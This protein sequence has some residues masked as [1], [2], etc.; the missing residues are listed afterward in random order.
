MKLCIGKFQFKF[1]CFL[2][3]LAACET[4]QKL[5]PICHW[6]RASEAEIERKIN[7]RLIETYEVKSTIIGTCN[8]EQCIMLLISIND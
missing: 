3:S 5:L 4:K 8:T 2:L 6:H 1:R 7:E